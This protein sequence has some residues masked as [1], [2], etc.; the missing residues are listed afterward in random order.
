MLQGRTKKIHR[1][2]GAFVHLS[3]EPSA[4]AYGPQERLR[5]TRAPCSVQEATYAPRLPAARG[6]E[7]PLTQFAETSVHKGRFA[8]CARRSTD[9]DQKFT[10]PVALPSTS[11]GNLRLPPTALR[12]GFDLLALRAR[13]KGDATRWAR[14]VQE[15]RGWILTHFATRPWGN[16]CG[17]L[18]SPIQASN[19]EPC[20]RKISCQRPLASGWWSS[21][22][23][24]A[25]CGVITRTYRAG[26]SAFQ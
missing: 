22:I 23:S 26:P 19:S 3:R 18:D 1:A 25:I 2:G 17:F 7:R 10:E 11:P 13:C 6:F 15:R 21:S 9:P 8:Y 20:R 4:S 16:L 24:A 12:S 5:P 14:A